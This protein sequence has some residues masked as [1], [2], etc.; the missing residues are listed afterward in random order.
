MQPGEPI[1]NNKAN[2]WRQKTGWRGRNDCCI[3]WNSPS[4]TK[5]ACR[6]ALSSQFWSPAM[7]IHTWLWELHCAPNCFPHHR[8]PLQSTM[9]HSAVSD[10]G[11]NH[12]TTHCLS[13]Q[14]NSS[15]WYGFQ[16]GRSHLL[17]YCK[18]HQMALIDLKLSNCRRSPTNTYHYQGCEPLMKASKIHPLLKIETHLRTRMMQKGLWHSHPWELKSPT[19]KGSN[20]CA[21]RASMRWCCIMRDPKQLIYYI[22]YTEVLQHLY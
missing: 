12:P 4:L 14:L 6:N 3:N 21:N 10:L 11:N 16:H 22:P 9:R 15:Q 5:A 1:H 18:R 13:S 20:F 17:F 19:E 8:H 7:A 2:T